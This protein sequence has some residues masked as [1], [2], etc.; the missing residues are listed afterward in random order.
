MKFRLFDKEDSSIDIVH[1]DVLDGVRAFA[2]LIV[3]WFHI[4]QQCWIM[5][6]LNTPELSFLGINNIDLDWLP[7]TG[8]MMV[9]MMIFLSGFC[10]YLPYARHKLNGDPLPSTGLFFKKRVARIVPSYLASIIIVLVYNIVNCSYTDP[11]FQLHDDTSFMGVDILTHLTFTFNLVPDT[12]N[13]SLLNNVLWTVALEVQFYIIFPLIQKCFSKKPVITYLTMNIISYA[14]TQFALG[15][16]NI[17]YYLHQ[18]P[19]YFSVYANG[20]MGAM[21]LVGISKEIK[22][23]KFLGIAAT[24]TSILCILVYRLM[25]K[26]LIMQEDLNVWQLNNRFVVSI[27]FLV[28]VIS[29]ALSVSAYRFIFANKVTVFL[30]TISFNLYIWHQF[31]CLAFKT[32]RI[33]YYSG[34]QAPNELGDQVWMWKL[35]IISFAAAFGAAIAATYLIEKPASKLIM[36]IGNKKNNGAPGNKTAAGKNTVRK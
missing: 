6:T 22:R 3:V 16:D 18:L 28:F 34:D 30:S 21:I 26:T 25:M 10:L 12:C 8:Y 11:G 17:P 27:L 19:T 9:T 32:H 4:W 29:T 2:V 13:Y 23:T 20:F 24:I 31:L 14:F 1:I 36:R 15:Q 35:L 7:R 33:P 5:P